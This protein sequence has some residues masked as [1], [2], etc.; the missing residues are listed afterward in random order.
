MKQQNKN[1]R[2]TQASP[3]FGSETDREYKMLIDGE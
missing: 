3:R 2:V 1:S